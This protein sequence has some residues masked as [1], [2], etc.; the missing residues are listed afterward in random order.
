MS[1]DQPETTSQVVSGHVSVMFLVGTTPAIL[2]FGAK[3]THTQSVRIRGG[4]SFGFYLRI[5]NS[6]LIFRII[7]FGSFCPCR[8]LVF[9]EFS[10]FLQESPSMGQYLYVTHWAIR[11]I[12]YMATDSDQSFNAMVRRQ[13]RRCWSRFRF[14]NSSLHFC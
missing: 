10:I 13:R 3:N 2:Q 7:L 12:Q 6:V 14:N 1:A 9:F 8:R 5:N 4:S 11:S